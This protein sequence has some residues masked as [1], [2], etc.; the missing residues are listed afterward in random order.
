MGGVSGGDAPA[1]LVL[2]VRMNDRKTILIDIDH[3]LADAFARDD[4]LN[5]DWD[6][7]HAA[8]AN[9]LPVHDL[10]TIVNAFAVGGLRIIGLT[11]RPGKW[12]T[13]TALWL[14]DHG[15]N[16]DEILMRDDLDYRS[17]PLVK[18][19]LVRDYFGNDDEVRFHVAALIDDR[20]D[21]IQAFA[22][23]GVTC[24]QAIVRRG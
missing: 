2:G 23:L 12:R 14:Y 13:M 3:V 8:A 10:V 11:A 15:I 6:S 20:D 1:A 22:G 18:L 17:A 5:G 24:L 4:M 7:Y 9:D 19:D 21:V 16:L